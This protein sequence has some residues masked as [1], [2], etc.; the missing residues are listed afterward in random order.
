V[1]NSADT[2]QAEPILDSLIA[3]LGALDVPL[4]NSD[5]NTL[6][7]ALALRAQLRFDLDRQSETRAD[8]GWLFQLDQDYRFGELASPRIALLWIE[9]QQE[10]EGRVRLPSESGVIVWVDGNRVDGVAVVPTAVGSHELL[11][12]VDN[13]REALTV[14]V[15]ANREVVV[16]LTPRESRLAQLFLRPPRIFLVRVGTALEAYNQPFSGRTLLP[17]YGRVGILDSGYI[18]EPPRSLSGFEIGAALR[19]YKHF[20]IGATHLKTEGSFADMVEAT[21]PSPFSTN[22]TRELEF[23]VV[24]LARTQQILHVEIAATAGEENWEASVFV[25]PSFMRVR[26]ELFDEVQIQEVGRGRSPEVLSVWSQE[27]DHDSVIGFNVGF[28]VSWMFARYFG[29]GGGV[30]YSRALSEVRFNGGSTETILGGTQ[31]SLGTRFRL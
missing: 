25:G 11:I 10:F 18:F 23:N 14:N 1:F 22:N 7:G 9:I 3:V 13:R 2:F 19:V 24:G 17:L 27:I 16:K 21:L 5:S 4:E 29:V 31:I 12:E 15:P 20:A 28:D 8:L 30:R 6:R 26:Q